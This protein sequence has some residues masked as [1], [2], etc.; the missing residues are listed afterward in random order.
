MKSC[1]LF[2]FFFLFSCSI[3]EDQFCGSP[4]RMDGYVDWCSRISKSM[5]NLFLPITFFFGNYFFPL[6]YCSL[7][8]LNWVWRYSW[9]IS[10]CFVY[11]I[12]HFKSVEVACSGMFRSS[13]TFFLHSFSL[14]NL[15]IWFIYLQNICE[16]AQ[17]QYVPPKRI[18][19]TWWW[20]QKKNKTLSE[21]VWSKC[22]FFFFV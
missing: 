12:A 2:F 9:T 1:S 3:P 18:W 10:M 11:S 14:V 13:Y 22:L 15:L 17:M 4:I 6:H 8:S 21:N 5:R 16:D 7:W 19:A 20:D